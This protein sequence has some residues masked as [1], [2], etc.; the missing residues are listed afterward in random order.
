MTNAIT[1]FNNSIAVPDNAPP[2]PAW[3][4]N[5]QASY[6][7]ALP[8]RYMSL[9]RLG[10]WLDERQAE[11]RVLTV[12]NVTCE[13]LYDPEK[14]EPKDGEWKPCLHFDETT[15]LLVINKSR[16]QQLK[17]LANSPM[18]ASWAK[19]GTVAL[20]AGIANSKAQIVISRVPT[21]GNADDVAAA[22]NADLF[23]DDDLGF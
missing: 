14:E 18:L 19:V 7:D 2:M 4:S 3:A 15:E 5:P 9:E 11:S 22:A 20:K 23:G 10:E 12:T 21:T 8:S 13:L 1:T 17:K 6:D 16:G